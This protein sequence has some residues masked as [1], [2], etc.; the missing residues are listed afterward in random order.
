MKVFNRNLRKFVSPEFITGEGARDLAGRYSSNFN[1]NRVLLVIDENIANCD[2]LS[3]V[4]GSLSENDVDYEIFSSI[5]ENP[6]VEEVMSGADLFKSSCCEG[7]VAAGGG[8]VLD[9]AKGIGIVAENGGHI[10]DYFGPDKINN[11][12]PPLIC[13]P[14]TAGSSADVSQYAVIS[15][16]SLR[17]KGLII[18][19]SLVPDLSLLDPIPL[20]TLPPDVAVNSAMDAM[21]HAIEGYCSNGSSTVTDT[22]GI[23]SIKM[24]AENM[25]PSY[26]RDSVRSFGVMIASLYAGLC[27]SNAGL[28]LIHSMAHAIGGWTGMSHGY[29]S[30]AVAGEVFG[31]NMKVT[32][33]RYQEIARIFMED[34]GEKPEESSVPSYISRRMMEIF[35][36]MET[37]SLSDLGIGKEDISELVRHTMN[38]PCVATNPRIPVEGDVERIY[39]NLL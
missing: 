21:I 2:W 28:G 39:L 37:P 34:G 11:P 19:K 15:D 26:W 38:D 3:S 32:P 35:G 30:F 12:M 9:C 29:I 18:S 24:L 31:Y 13:I 25:G 4:T 22:F 10:T 17:T 16:R 7:I 20:S 6:C 33:E 27:F 5:T 1:L 14:S 36:Y 8:S 23:S